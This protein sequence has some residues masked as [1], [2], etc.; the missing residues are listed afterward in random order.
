MP[1]VFRYGI[2]ETITTDQGSVFT[3]R[4]MKEFAK[5]TGFKLLTSTPYYVQANGQVE[6]ANKFIINL[7]KKHVG[8][9][10]KSW[11]QTL[12]QILQA[13]RTSPKEATNT[14]PFRLTFGHDA[15]FPVEICLQSVRIQR[16]ND[17][18]IDEYWNLML[19]ELVELDEERLI[20]LD[21]LI[22]QKEKVA[23]AYNKKVKTKM[24][25]LD[26]YVWK[27]ILPMDQKYKSL[28]KWSPYWEGLFK[29]VQ[30]FTNNAYE[31]K[32]L[33]EDCRILRIN[34]KYLKKYKPILQEITIET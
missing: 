1:E 25:A 18:A 20:A 8:R 19:D 28:G 24:F 12:D 4:K 3:G 15:V 16:Q 22:K 27:V 9:K 23:N 10:P 31:I 32:E 17:M 5:E 11:H 21:R 34:G 26:D 33:S 13:C 29:I 6:A 14:T 7:I 30:V 2:P